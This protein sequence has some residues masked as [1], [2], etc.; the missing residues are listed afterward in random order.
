VGARFDPH[1]LRL[2]APT[3]STLRRV[4]QT[5]DAHALDLLV[6]AWLAEWATRETDG[7]L[8]IALDGKVLRGAWDTGGQVTLFSAMLHRTKTTIAQI[9]IPNK[10]T[11]VTQVGRLLDGIDA[12]HVLITVDAAHTVTN[13]AELITRVKGWDYIMTVKANTPTLQHHIADLL[14][15]RVYHHPPAHTT[16]ERG[17]GRITTWS[18]WVTPATGVD[19]PHAT[20]LACLRRDVADLAGQPLSKELAL[21]ITSATT[22]RCPPHRLAEHVRGHWA[23][24]SGHWIRDTL[25]DEDDH[26][27][28]TGNGPHVMATLRNLTIGLIRR[29]GITKI[30]ETTEAINR[31]RTRALPLIS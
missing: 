17:H 26:Q 6:G 19:F 28:V 9:R 20:Q 11:E 3:E 24:E 30:K 8:V 2:V 23:I 10:T 4:L 13:T 31:D 5:V 29:A 22:Q 21:I 14:A 1:K 15:P 18:I 27:S 7:T 12:P 16:T 25:W